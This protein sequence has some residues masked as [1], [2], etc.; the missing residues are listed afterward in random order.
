MRIYE[1]EDAGISVTWKVKNTGKETMYFT[2]GG[3]PAFNV[4]VLEGTKFTDYYLYFEGKDH[5]DYKLLDKASGCIIAA[6]REVLPLENSMYHPE[7]LKRLFLI[8]R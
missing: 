6:S 8:I 1:L 7:H 5:L 3:H 4:P 2:I